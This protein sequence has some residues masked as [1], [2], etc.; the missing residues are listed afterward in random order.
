MWE[1]LATS[2]TEKSDT[3]KQYIK[4]PKAKI[5]LEKL[6]QE[7]ALICFVRKPKNGIALITMQEMMNRVKNK[8]PS[9]GIIW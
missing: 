5:I 9:S 4:T 2:N 7:I 8:L 6:R 1:L 3:A